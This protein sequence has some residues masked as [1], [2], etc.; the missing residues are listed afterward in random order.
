[1]RWSKGLF[2]ACRYDAISGPARPPHDRRAIL[3]DSF[4]TQA[5]DL[6]GSAE[7]GRG[8]LWPAQSEGHREVRVPGRGRAQADNLWAQRYRPVVAVRG[9]VRQSGVY[10]HTLPG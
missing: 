5:A 7:D 2:L 3:T 10:G 8:P 9:L 6:W 4:P 1:M